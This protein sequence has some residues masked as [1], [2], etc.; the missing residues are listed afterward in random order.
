MK[1]FVITGILCFL[2]SLSF[3]QKKAVSAAKNEIKAASPN[4]AEARALI[5]DALTHPETAN[6]AETWYV[7][8]SIEDKQLDNERLK[9]MLGQPPNE[10]VMYDALEKILPYF[11]KAIELDQ[12]PDVKG[13]VK[14][15]F[16]K[17]IRAKL[18]ANRLYYI[19]AGLFANEKQNYKKAYENFKNFTEIPK[20]DIFKGEK[21]EI[22]ERDS[23]ELQIKYYAGLMAAAI[24]DYQAAISIFSSL[25]NMNYMEKEI[26]ENLAIQYI[27]SGDT[28]TYEKTLKE[29]IDKFPK[30]DAFLLS[31]INLYMSTERFTDAIA[32][33]EKAISKNPTSGE[34]FDKLGQ[35][36]EVEKKSDEALVNMKKAIEIEPDNK[37]FLFNIG[38]LYFNLGV[39]KRI[40]AD[41]NFSNVS[42][43]K[44]LDEQSLNYFKLAMPFLEKVFKLDPENTKAIYALRNIYYSLK[45]MPEYEKMDAL[46]GGDK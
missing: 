11:L 35:I 21:W 4:F 15:K 38:R 22:N 29:S 14:P 17:D 30:I 2:V 3:G 1:K 40:A 33:L 26:Y 36:Y 45:M 9:E 44:E 24:P 28:L 39:E 25:K 42:K 31:L 41:D 43:S 46:Y 18:R 7:A 13:K 27:L 34:L 8:G 37:E 32:Y 10:A 23:L 20:M 19:N 16:I 6:Q 12:M 5:K